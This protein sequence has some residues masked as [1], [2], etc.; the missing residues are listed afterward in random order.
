MSNGATRREAD[1][2]ITG[3]DW[4]VTVDAGRRVIRDGAV[5]IKDGAFAAVAK[6]AEIE[7]EWQA[8]AV[9]SG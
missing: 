4:L 7:A 9:T 1:H 3:I 6:S 5:A 8:A 2:L